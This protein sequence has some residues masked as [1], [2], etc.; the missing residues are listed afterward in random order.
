MAAGLVVAAT[1]IRGAVDPAIGAQVPFAVH[2]L[3]VVLAAS[4]GGFD[5][6]LLAVLL[7]AAAVEFFFIAPRQSP[8]YGDLANL[9]GI[10]LFVAIATGLAWLTSRWRAAERE[11]ERSRHALA[12]RAERLEF[13]GTLLQQS[14][15][16]VFVR[17]RDQRIILW[18][19]GA[20][21]LYQWTASEAIGRDAD[22]LLRTAGASSAIKATLAATG[23]WSGQ[24]RHTRKDGAVVI[25]DSRQVRIEPGFT[26]EVNRDVT[27]QVRAEQALRASQQLLQTT[28]A[29]FPTVIA[30]KDRE[31]RFIDV[32]PAV[33]R[34]L[35]LPKEQIVGRTMHH[36]IPPEAADI[37]HRHELAVMESRRAL[38]FEEATPLPT[39]TLHHLNTNFPLIDDA[40]EVYGTGHIS[41]DISALRNAEEALRV[42]ERKLKA[43]T[44]AATESI[45]LLDRERVLA[46]NFT[47]ARRFGRTVDEVIG[48]AW[49]SALPPDLAASRAAKLEEV[50]RTGQPVRFEDERAGVRFD[51]TFY[52]AFDANGAVFAVAAYSRDITEQRRAEDVL[53]EVS[54][55][56]AYHMNHSPL[57]VIEFD[58]DM[59]LTRWTGAAE[60]VFG[61]SAEEVLGKRMDEFHWI[62]EEDQPGVQDVSE[63]LRTGHDPRRFSANRNYRKDGGIVFCEW[64]NSS[65]FDRAGN[66]R[67]ILSL[68][69]DVTE[70]TRLEQELRAQAQQLATANR[71][72]DDFLA[73]LSHELR[74]PINA[75]L[76]WAQILTVAEP[77]ADRLRRGIE[78][79][80][81]NARLQVQMIEDLLDVSRIVTGSVRLDVRRVEV[82]AL[83]DHAVDA[84]RPAADAKQLTFTA[85]VEPGLA[86]CADPMR[87]QQ[88]L[89]NLLSNAV[90]FTPSGG[91]VAIDAR[92]SDGQIEF[93][94]S[95]SGHG[96]RPDFLPHVFERFQQADSSSTRAHGGLGLGL[97]IV[98]HIVELHGGTAAVSSD[99]QNQGAVFT[100]RLPA[101]ATAS[102][103]AGSEHPEQ[104]FTEL[105]VEGALENV[106]VLA[107]DDD[108]DAREV[109]TSILTAAGAT[110]TCA[111]SADEARTLLPRIR[112][113]VLVC[114]IAMPGIDGYDFI[115]EV[116]ASGSTVAGVPAVA[117]TAYV[118]ADDRAAALAAGYDAQLTKPVMAEELVGSIALLLHH[119]RTTEGG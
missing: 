92:R 108:A 57:A 46:A 27:E 95:D 1:L 2:F 84:I 9:N 119:P 106:R 40:G 60:R 20:R 51:H 3:A 113:D 39:G 103:G 23:S 70:K 30:F 6:G 52:P 117:L 13:Q 111:A 101:G 89:W 15:D 102:V 7:S 73:T 74:T 43:L 21:Q 58:A 66:M 47:A 54:Q 80:A 32:N 86:L 118:R 36:F 34:T 12:Q 53:R 72:K 115:R 114:D 10:G 76:G 75:I 98:R 18:N 24:V 26:L 68:V 33:E 16:A 19:D 59:R 55:R 116:R 93:T 65:L 88:V 67:S 110:V 4:L 100:V 50:Y 104:P 48:I 63:A 96:I 41:Q 107:L 94:V 77:S 45:W 29:N 42:N 44:D 61:W 90:K 109:V 25:S 87:V 69:L 56:L 78:T 83:V 85:S 35:G 82:G 49:K 38:Q 5:S 28:M 31:G 14:Y 37:L 97:A 79:I 8:S 99:G 112:P 105:A 11:L 22:E 91:F 17:D 64:Y 81:R 62:Y 71:L